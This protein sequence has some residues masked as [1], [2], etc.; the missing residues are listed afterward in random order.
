MSLLDDENILIDNIRN[1]D[2]NLILCCKDYPPKDLLKII[3][4]VFYRN[5]LAKD[6]YWEKS[7]IFKNNYY[8]KKNPNNDPNRTIIIFTLKI[9]INRITLWMHGR[10]M[11]HIF[12]IDSIH[13]LDA[14]KEFGDWIRKLGF[15]PSPLVCLSDDIKEY[16]FNKL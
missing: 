1:N 2:L 6:L 15:N 12:D 11:Y 3:R 16:R 9:E 7:D 5:D 10:N 13:M 14:Q 8:L 4:F